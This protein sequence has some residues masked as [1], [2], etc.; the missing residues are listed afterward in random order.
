MNHSLKNILQGLFLSC[1]HLL[2]NGLVVMKNVVLSGLLL[3]RFKLK[4]CTSAE[5]D[6]FESSLID[7]VTRANV[8]PS[9]VVLIADN[10]TEPATSSTQKKPSLS[11][12]DSLM[13]NSRSDSTDN[14]S[15]D[16]GCIVKKYLCQPCLPQPL[17]YWKSHADSEFKCKLYQNI[18]V[19][20]PLLH[21]SKEYSVLLERFSDQKDVAYVIKHLNSS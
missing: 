6:K 16:I 9:E 11:F 19:F 10:T 18:C 3:P 2:T 12:F 14:Q 17:E 20:Q 8:T 7:K 1:V 15:L 21:Q 4:W 13:T 5:S